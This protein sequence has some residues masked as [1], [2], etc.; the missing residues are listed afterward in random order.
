MR[1]KFL[2]F[3]AS[4][5]IVSFVI[6]SCL[7]DDTNIEYSPD[8]TIHAFELD[9]IGYGITYKFTID[10]QRGEIY[11]EDSIPVHADTII[12]KILIKTLTTVSGIVTMKNKADEDSIININDSIALRNPLKIK[13]WSTEA[14]AGMPT[15]TTK[16]YTI[17]VR[18]HK[19]DPDSL[20]WSYAGKISD[21]ITGAQKSIVFKD[22]VL[23]YSEQGNELKV[24][25]SQNYSDWSTATVEG[26]DK[27]PNSIM[28][29]N[30][31]IL[32]T[33]DNKVYSSSDGQ[34]WTVSDR[35]LGNV[36]TFVSKLPVYDAES[37]T[38]DIKDYKI[39]YIKEEGAKKYFYSI[40]E[41]N[42]GEETSEEI[43][44]GEVNDRF[45]IAN[46]SY[47]TFSKGKMAQNIV[48]GKHN[49]DITTTIN[50]KEVSATVTWGYDGKTWAEI[51]TTSS[52]GYCPAFA[53]PTVVYYNGLLYIWGDKFESIYV[54]ESEGFAWKKADKKFAFPVYDWSN[55]SAA[56]TTEQPEFRGRTQ[57]SV[58][59]DTKNQ[60]IYILFGK[61]PDVTF[62][63]IVVTEGD[64]DDDQ[65]VTTTVTRRYSHDSEVWRGRL[66]QLWFDLAN[67]G[68]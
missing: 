36:I 2:S 39:T 22:K 25:S 59:Q 30:D 37:P 11:N 29:L 24:Y 49:P 51:G 12:D 6:T 26:L 67:A 5:F 9:T 8:A 42:L 40:N 34:S 55:M 47:T 10:Q 18:V 45:P 35:F 68:N 15:G 3:I 33:V 19:Q 7:N 44:C 64:E 31:R 1:I 61:E 20:K 38:T 43:Q 21:N 13:V 41:S 65:T 52:V 23:T 46:I 48:V 63:E 62:E 32:A 66:N 16:E 27:L 56:P 14:L 54:S 58:I 4:F 28:P 53:N 50:S 57:Y 60:Y 17:T